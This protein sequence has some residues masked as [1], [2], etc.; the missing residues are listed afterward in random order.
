MQ[1][2]TVPPKANSEM[3]LILVLWEYDVKLQQLILPLMILDGTAASALHHWA[4]N[5]CLQEQNWVRLLMWCLKKWNEMSWGQSGCCER[6]SN[7]KYDP[8]E[9]QISGTCSLTGSW[10]GIGGWGWDMTA[11]KIEYFFS[12]SNTRLMSAHSPPQANICMTAAALRC[13]LISPTF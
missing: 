4:L 12:S 6:Y 7:D 2:F 3:K 8:V 1:C 9:T 13:L 10:K 11:V 5:I